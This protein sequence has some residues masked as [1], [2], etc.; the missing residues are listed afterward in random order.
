M[1]L[2]D[3][4]YFAAPARDIKPGSMRR[5]MIA[6]EPIALGRSK[7]GA[8]FAMRDICPHRA[9]PLSAGRIVESDESAD[10]ATT[11]ECPYHGWRFRAASGA[12]AHIP[13][14]TAEQSLPLDRI[15]A[16][17]V[18]VEEKNG[19]IWVYVREDWRGNQQPA[20]AAPDL[21]VEGGKPKMIIP[22]EFH[23]H[24]DQAAIGLIDPAHGPFVH[25]QWWWRTAAS[26]HEKEKRFE[27][28]ERGFV[29]VKHTPSSN[30]FAY[31][32]LGGKPT[33]EIEFRL[34]GLRFETIQNAKHTVL[35]LTAVTPMT[36]KS[37]QVHQIF[38][39]DVPLFDVLR[40]FMQPL[41][42]RFLNQDRDM[43]DLQQEGLKF[44]PKL[45]LIDDADTLARWYMQMKREWRAAREADR[46]FNNPVKPATLRWRS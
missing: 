28:T 10:G 3:I 36:D 27:P 1:P 43:V 15:Q 33:T 38:F 22:A 7:A 20:D 46:P 19:L 30:S 24:I 2:K 40:P 37:T 39:W 42:Q 17:N 5:V 12:C 9:S 29:M 18:P 35:G 45:M 8:I 25:Q 14:L 13:S 44:D 6:N 11:V 26:M 34:P 4:W 16:G 41:G 31:K 32:L 21:P 23:C